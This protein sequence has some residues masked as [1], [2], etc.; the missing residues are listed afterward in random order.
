MPNDIDELKRLVREAVKAKEA[1]GTRGLETNSR[2]SRSLLEE[3]PPH[4]VHSAARLFSR[5]L[6]E[7]RRP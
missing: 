4:P 1:A 2:N 6:D 3:V 7:L 5:R